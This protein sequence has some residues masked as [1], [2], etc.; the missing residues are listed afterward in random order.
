M[1]VVTFRSVF[2]SPP[3][4]FSVPPRW[5]LQWRMTMGHAQLRWSLNPNL[6]KPPS[7]QV[8][9]RAAVQLLLVQACG[10]VHAAHAAR[11]PVAPLVEM[12]DTLERVSGAARAANDDMPLRRALAF[13]QADDQVLL[14]VGIT[15]YHCCI[16]HAEFVLHQ[17]SAIWP[18]NSSWEGC[19]RHGWVSPGSQVCQVHL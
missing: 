19:A 3:V 18:Q 7:A 5:L 13:A 12:L 17:P 4:S 1:F 6:F 11:M 14:C 8:R 9:V 2:P 16:G 10:E 15:A